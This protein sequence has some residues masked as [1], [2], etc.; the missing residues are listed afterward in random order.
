MRIGIIDFGTNTLRLN[1]FEYDESGYKMVYDNVIYSKIV[2]NTVDNSLSQDGIE[3]IIQSIEEHQAVCRH[4]RC[5]RIECFSTASLRYINNAN[6]VIDQVNFR[7]GIDIRMISGEEEALYDYLALKSVN[8][9][10][11]GVGVDLGGGSFQCFVFDKNG[12][13]KSESFPL[14]SSRVYKNF[15]CG[16]IPTEIEINNISNIVKTSLSEK[17]FTPSSGTLLSMGGTAKAIDNIYRNILGK[18]DYISINDLKGLLSA[19]IENP[20]E[21]LELFEER[22]PSRKNT[23]APGIAVLLSIMEYMNL[24]TMKVFD[25]GVR[26]GFLQAIISGKIAKPQSPLDYILGML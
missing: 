14:G 22:M 10:D 8:Y 20:D 5:D 4:Y 15:V 19:I 3:H 18:N 17:S 6:S 21:S 9:I 26:E 7:S 11:N 16:E 12:P 1:I 23:I 2:E 13:I 24:D 25:V